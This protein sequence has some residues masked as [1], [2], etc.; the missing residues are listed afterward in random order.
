VSKPRRRHLRLELAKNVRDVGGYHTLDGRVTRWR[1]LLRGGNLAGLTE[2]DGVR[3]AEYGLRTV[4]DLRRDDEVAAAP[5][6]LAGTVRYVRVPFG[7]ISLA[8]AGSVAEVYRL[9]L[10]LRQECLRI[11]LAELT[12]PGALPALVQCTAGKDRTG[13]AIALALGCV[14][15]PDDTVV[16]DFRRG[17]YAPEPMRELL[18]CLAERYG[19][20]SAYLERVGFARDRQATLRLALTQPAR[21]PST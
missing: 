2:A 16:A 15:V 18:V 8:P 14:G 17:G 20:I 4:I 7:D 12:A 13:I 10:E 19:R 9:A 1:T 11:V 21:I 6:A 3:L 5:C